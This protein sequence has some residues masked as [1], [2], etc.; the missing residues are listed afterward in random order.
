MRSPAARLDCP[1]L[2]ALG[3]P[4]GHNADAPLDA[5]R[6]EGLERSREFSRVVADP[7]AVPDADRLGSEVLDIAQHFVSENREIGGIVLECTDLPPF[8]ASLRRA[9][10]LP[11]FDIVTLAHWVHESICGDRWGGVR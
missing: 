2:L 7:E 3:Q 1:R 4:P 11:V 8:A 10:A 5:M 6:V 9:L